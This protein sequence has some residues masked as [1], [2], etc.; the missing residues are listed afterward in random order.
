M[1]R[2][3]DFK[4]QPT[5][6]PLPVPVVRRPAPIAPTAKRGRWLLLLVVLG[7]ALL[8]GAF[9]LSANRPA[10]STQST[11]TATESTTETKTFS[12]EV[13]VFDGGSGEAAAKT[14]AE[15]LNTAGVTAR[16]AGKTLTSYNKTEI[17]YDAAYQDIAEQ[18]AVALSDRSPKL[19]PSKVS[20][21]F[22]VQIFIGKN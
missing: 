11:T 15:Q 16:Y 5:K 10:S 21:V 2:D 20:G 22:T 3:F 19:T 6:K 14:V 12:T 4:R 13:Q 18:A 8:A 7:L 9:F 1:A 17:W